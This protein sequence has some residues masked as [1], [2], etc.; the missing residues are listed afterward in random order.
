MEAPDEGAAIKAGAQQ[1]GHDPKRLIA[2]R[3]R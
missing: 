2:V 3:R 1:F